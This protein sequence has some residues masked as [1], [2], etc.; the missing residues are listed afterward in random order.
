VQAERIAGYVAA[1]A[2][3]GDK[4]QPELKKT[5][6]SSQVL[7]RYQMER[8]ARTRLISVLARQLERYR[9]L[10]PAWIEQRNAIACVVA[11]M[12]EELTKRSEKINH[13]SIEQKQ[14]E[15]YYTQKYDDL[16]RA[17]ANEQERAL[18][19]S[20]AK[21]AELERSLETERQTI[22]IMKQQEEKNAQDRASLTNTLQQLNNMQT[23]INQS[24]T[25]MQEVQRQ[26]EAQEMLHQARLQDMTRRA[27]MQAMATEA[28]TQGMTSETK[29]NGIRT[30]VSTED[31]ARGV[32]SQTTAQ[33][34]SSQAAQAFP[35][36][37]T[38]Y[39]FSQVA[40]AFPQAA[41]PHGFPAGG[42]SQLEIFI[43][44][45]DQAG[46]EKRATQIQIMKAQEEL[47][48]QRAN[49]ARLE[50]FVKKVAL[51]TDGGYLLDKDTKRE[52][53]A[54]LAA[55]AR[56]RD[57][58]PK[59]PPRRQYPDPFFGRKCVAC[60]EYDVR[61]PPGQPARSQ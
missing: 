18:A 47:N 28:T 1:H 58:R 19:N 60:D 13:L 23:S 2:S 33:H 26:A 51:G 3:H 56:M 16:V 49:S 38:Q 21:K 24:Q 25:E 12:D 31:V 27:Q 11:R 7:S 9:D 55:A 34:G 45:K 43:R 53:A 20:R 41:A 57:G 4:S 36:A 48:L 35:P 59:S 46:A 32:I 52:A 39:D 5:L 6:H 14:L 8:D 61:W 15:I 50:E 44:E 54:L 22:Q 10:L 29:V 42:L 37:T 40:Q 17:L 30:E